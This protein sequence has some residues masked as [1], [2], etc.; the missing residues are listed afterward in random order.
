MSDQCHIINRM[1]H[2]K[3]E[4]PLP[5]H[6]S[7]GELAQRFGKFFPDKIQ[8]IRDFLD[9]PHSNNQSENMWH[10]QPL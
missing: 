10:D 1:L 9:D 6:I 5:L 4:T 8:S 3:E 7:E 2:R